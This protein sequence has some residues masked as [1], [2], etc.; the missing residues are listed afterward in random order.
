MYRFHKTVSVSD[1]Y[2]MRDTVHIVEMG[3]AGRWVKLLSDIRRSPMLVQNSEDEVCFL[4]GGKMF[5]YTIGANAL[6][7]HH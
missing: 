2:K 3:G 6:T 7:V 1:V 4:G 5:V